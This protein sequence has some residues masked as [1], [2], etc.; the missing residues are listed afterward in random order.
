[1]PC[2]HP[3]G[4][5]VPSPDGDCYACLKTRILAGRKVSEEQAR[6]VG[7]VSEDPQGTPITEPRWIPTTV[8]TRIDQQLEEIAR[9]RDIAPGW[10]ALARRILE[11]EGQ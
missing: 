2:P 1:V 11:E 10:Y 9:L 5:K 4:L 8:H 7:F 3:Y 6:F